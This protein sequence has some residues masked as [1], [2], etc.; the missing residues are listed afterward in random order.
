MEIFQGAP[1]AILYH[2]KGFSHR[3]L[4]I[5]TS[6]HTCTQIYTHSHN[7]T[8]CQAQLYSS[9]AFR[10]SCSERIKYNRFLKRLFFKRN[11]FCYWS[12]FCRSQFYAVMRLKRR[13]SHGTCGLDQP[14]TKKKSPWVARNSSWRSMES[15]G[16]RDR[17]NGFLNKNVWKFQLRNLY[18]DN[19]GNLVA[20]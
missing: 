8:A 3:N 1:E 19:N 15:P 12:Q 13:N 14:L 4:L 20:F 9:H 10:N 11:W 17:F 7:H 5:N 16:K 6:R 18:I 2:K